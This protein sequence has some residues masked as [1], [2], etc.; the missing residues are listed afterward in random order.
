MAASA[1]DTN[2]ASDGKHGSSNDHIFNWKAGLMWSVSVSDQSV[3]SLTISHTP[4]EGEC[5]IGCTVLAT[6][7]RPTVEC[8][9]CSKMELCGCRL[10]DKEWVTFTTEGK[11][12]RSLISSYAWKQIA[13]LASSSAKEKAAKRDFTAMQNTL[14]RWM[15]VAFALN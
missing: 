2:S 6:V 12:H 4:I 7:A 13:A 1:N 11:P 9:G 10:K 15:A 8:A 14:V 3:D 5:R